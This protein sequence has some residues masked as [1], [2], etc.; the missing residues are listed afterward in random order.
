M[1]ENNY[2]GSTSYPGLKGIRHNRSMYLGGVGVLDVLH[3]PRAL[4][5]TVQEVVSNSIDEFLVGAGEEIV[6]TIHKDNAVTVK[7]NGRG[8]RKGPGDSFDDV[9]GSL[10]VP[11]TSGKFEG[12][13]YSNMG[14]A[15]MHGIGLKATN[16]TSRYMTLHA[17]SPTT[18][19]VDSGK[20]D[21]NNQPIQ[22]KQLDGGLEEYKITLQLED[23]LESEIIRKWSAD[24]VEQVS[25]NSFR[26]K[27]TDE[28]LK[29]GTTITYLPDDGP[30][31]EEH[32][33]PVFESINWINGDLY[34]RFESSAFLNA[35]LKV[36][37]IDE[38]KN[39]YVIDDETGDK[40]DLDEPFV[41][42]WYYENGID[43]YVSEIAET[44]TLLS[45]MKHPITFAED[46]TYEDMP[47]RLQASFIFTDDT[48]ENLRSF[49]NGVPTKD[50]GPH[51]DGFRTAVTKVIND[52]AKENDLNKVKQ[53]K[54]SKTLD[55]FSQKDVFEGITGVFEIRLPSDIAKFEG[56][57]KEKLGTTQANPVVKEITTK[58]L[59]NWLYDNKDA[60]AQIISKIIESKVASD[61]AIKARQE[62]KKARQT[63]SIDSLK[64]SSKLKP[65]TGNDPTKKELFIT[66]GDS[67]SNIER[68][69]KTQGIM[70]LRGKILNVQDLNLSDVLKNEEI[71]T[72]TSAFGTGIGSAFDIS[73]LQY[74]KIILATDAD[75]DGQHILMLLLTLIF[76][77]F[78]P[79]IE[80][81]H[82]YVAIPPLYKATKYVKGQPINK[83]Y[84]SET[85]INNDRA[86]L[87]AEGYTLQRFKGLG[88][89]N[90]ED[91]GKAIA[92]SET[93]R[94]AQIT[95]RDAELAKHKLM[96]LMGKESS[97]RK[98]WVKE[99]I[100]Y[101][102]L[103]NVI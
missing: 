54:K 38:R 66:E 41:K 31:S 62:A 13:G 46:M 6:I 78:R 69:Q 57:T 75:S 27:A 90:P 77:Y 87:N 52:Y 71:S 36:T 82:V 98:E 35:K 44:Q 74:Y 95:I 96:V 42:S 68:D 89:M 26:I 28:I 99:N 55:A 88:E 8:M 43:E 7:D 61:A 1:I 59:T 53:G 14:T 47:F 34:P 65:A 17:I 76:K 15:G 102:E 67:A 21:K 18:I 93:R 2:V 70:P 3:A 45:K 50:G 10:T 63:K 73:D 29:T 51:M 72:L 9:I 30:E 49:A 4:N 24:E 101:D 79:L 39:A 11:H 33:A 40:I 25:V 37:F 23:V 58:H 32:K 103:Y 81:G 56:Q 60:A 12:S 48:E 92:N 19:L 91:V 86:E 5:Q 94:I 84:Y 22:V 100:N 64:V 20:K 83:W 97:F 85:E 80:N 16:A